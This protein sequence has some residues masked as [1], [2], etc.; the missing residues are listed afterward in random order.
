MSS[1]QDHIRKLAR[2][3]ADQIDGGDKSHDAPQ[4]GDATTETWRAE[5]T[6]LERRLARLEAQNGGTANDYAAANGKPD[7]DDRNAYAPRER[8]GALAAPVR[9]ETHDEAAAIHAPRLLGGGGTYVSAVHPSQQRFGIDLAIA[10]LVDH[11]ES[12]KRC[13][14]EPGDKPCDNCGMCSSRGF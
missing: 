13:D 11:F 8:S 4:T 3:I 10:E 14:M 6:R 12:A 2:R 9:R 1:E 5:V 7:K